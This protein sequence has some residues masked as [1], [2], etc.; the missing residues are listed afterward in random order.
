MIDEDVCLIAAITIWL[1]NA[2]TPCW[3][4]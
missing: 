2:A 3:S 4:N 1:P